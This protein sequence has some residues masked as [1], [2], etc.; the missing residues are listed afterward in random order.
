MDSLWEPDVSFDVSPEVL[1]PEVA[2]QEAK[3]EEQQEPQPPEPVSEQTPA[4]AELVEV[5]LSADEFTALEERILRAVALVK[6]ER[7]ARTEAEARAARAEAQLT[8]QVTGV[9][10]LEKEV[11]ALKAERDHVRERVERLLS[12]LDA[13]EL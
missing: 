3:P 12:E 5:A 11:T 1:R 7:G 4:A 2:S 8:E 9:E 13:L 10:Q 6:R